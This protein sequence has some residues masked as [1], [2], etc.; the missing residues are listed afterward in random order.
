MAALAC[1]DKVKPIF[2]YLVIKKDK[3]QKKIHLA[4]RTKREKK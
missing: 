3:V 1:F 2:Q 4:A